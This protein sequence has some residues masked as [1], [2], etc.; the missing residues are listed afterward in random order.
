MFVEEIQSSLISPQHEGDP[1]LLGVCLGVLG[2]LDRLGSRGGPRR[3]QLLSG[4]VAVGVDGVVGEGG[5]GVR[6]GHVA[7]IRCWF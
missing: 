7:E 5:G 4:G 3:P 2:G 6:R 1:G